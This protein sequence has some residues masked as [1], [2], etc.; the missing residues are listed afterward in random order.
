MN[1]ERT[2]AI[3]TKEE[4]DGGHVPVDRLSLSHL[5]IEKTRDGIALVIIDSPHGGNGRQQYLVDI[6]PI[7]AAGIQR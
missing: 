7:I 5:K 4:R 2:E 3:G 1:N 6:E